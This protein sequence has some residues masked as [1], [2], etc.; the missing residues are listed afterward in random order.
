MNQVARSEDDLGNGGRCTHLRT[1]SPY[2]VLSGRTEEAPVMSDS[3]T[4]PS[5][6]NLFIDM[7]RVTMKQFARS[8][9]DLGNGGR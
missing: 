8:E 9:G 6:W 3:I 4:H 2:W 5:C 1:C 7:L